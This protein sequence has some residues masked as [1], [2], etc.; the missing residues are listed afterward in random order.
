MSAS[1]QC[2]QHL[3]LSTMLIV[4]VKLVLQGVCFAIKIEIFVVMPKKVSIRLREIQLKAV[5]RLPL[6]TQTFINHEIFSLR[7]LLGPRT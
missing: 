3:P 1:H 6:K 4:N 2:E 5:F 7:I